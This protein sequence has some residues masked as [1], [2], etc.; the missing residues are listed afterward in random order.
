MFLIVLE[1]INDLLTFVGSLPANDS[2][3]LQQLLERVSGIGKVDKENNTV[4][5]L[6]VVL[7]HVGHVFRLEGLG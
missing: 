2:G 3:T 6:H 7:S 1:I 5:L 4:S